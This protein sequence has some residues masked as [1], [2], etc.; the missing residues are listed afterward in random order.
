MY[1][2]IYIYIYIHTHIS[3]DQPQICSRKKKIKRRR[4]LC[5]H[6]NAHTRTHM[7]AHLD[8]KTNRTETRQ[9]RG[10]SICTHIHTH[11]HIRTNRFQN[12][13]EKKNKTN[14]EGTIFEYTIH[15][16]PLVNTYTH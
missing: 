10:H 7:R 5:S 12:E 6:T 15:A 2:T 11:E 14:V 9:R 8:L 4:A 3:T 16:Q 13:L 1:I